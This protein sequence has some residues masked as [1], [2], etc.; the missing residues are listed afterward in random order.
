MVDSILFSPSGTQGLLNGFSV[1]LL[2]FSNVVSDCMCSGYQCVG[3][4]GRATEWTGSFLFQKWPVSSDN[5]LLGIVFPPA[6][7]SYA[8]QPIRCQHRRYVTALIFECAPK[9][10]VP[11]PQYTWN[12]SPAY[13]LYLWR[14]LL[15]LSCLLLAHVLAL[16]PASRVTTP[17]LSS[18][19]SSMSATN[20]GVVQRLYHLN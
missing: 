6:P 1:T 11:R 7:K 2:T 15:C 3:R 8:V 19:G 12:T 10:Q 17:Q 18:P 5:V 13:S 9:L 14:S 16:V 4:F 20:G